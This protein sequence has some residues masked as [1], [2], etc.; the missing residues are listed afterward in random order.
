M[1]SNVELFVKTPSV[2]SL[3]AFRKSDLLSL[4]KRYSLDE[5]KPSMRKRQILKIVL[6]H[7]IEDEIL[8]DSALCL[9][10]TENCNDF[11]LRKLELE[12]QF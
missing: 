12:F 2:E 8:V 10:K 7:L 11:E 1:E 5:A 4:A 3:G 6:D 9:I